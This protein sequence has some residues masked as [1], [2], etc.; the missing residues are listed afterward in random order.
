MVK[1]LE[2]SSGNVGVG[3]EVAAGDFS[4]ELLNSGCFQQFYSVDAYANHHDVDEYKAVIGRFR[5]CGH[6]S[7]LRLRFDEALDLFDDASPDFICIDGY[8]HTGQDG[9]GPYM[10][11]RKK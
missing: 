3:L 7:L 11:G 6:Y 8:A 4:A 2:R 1:L 10:L 9:G 5:S